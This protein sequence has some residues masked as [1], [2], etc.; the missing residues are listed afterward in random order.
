MTLKHSIG[1]AIVLFWCVMNFLLIKRQIWAP[2]PPL[3]VRGTEMITEPRQEWWGIY[4]RGE[5][6]GYTS[7]T[8]EPHLDGY[9][10]TD[11]SMLRLN[12]MGTTRN[13][14]TRLA[15]NVDKEWVLKNFDFELQSNDVHFKSRGKVVPGKLQLEIESAGHTSAQEIALTQPPYLLAALKPL[16]ATQQ[17]E[18][19]KEHFFATFDPSTLSQQITSVV[20]EAR[21]QTLIGN[22]REPAIRFRQKFKGLSVL[23]WIDGQG[24]TLKEESPGG[25]ALL[26]ETQQE[27]K[28]FTGSR[29]VPLDMIA[30][31][32]VP[33]GATITEPES[34]SVLRLKLTGVN[35]ANFGLNQGRQQLSENELRVEREKVSPSDTFQIPL[36]DRRFSSFLQSTAFLQ[37]DHPRIRDLARQILGSETDAL[38]A[39]LRLKNWVY[40]EI[41]K[42]PTVSVPNALEVLQTRKGDCNE[43]TVLF[44]AL[45]RAAGIPARTV[46]GVV[47]LRNAFY[48]H[49]WSE[50]WLGTWISLDSVL[51][52]FPADVTHIKF[53][54]GEIDR[55]VNVL[56]LI[57][58][59][60]IEVL[61]EG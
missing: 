18:P 15:M 55:Q 32:S 51:D 28:G 59:L 16:V 42:E 50:V 48:Y 56:Q 1:L 6:I 17:L 14:S 20:I 21:E 49:A 8:I 53:I 4:Y 47:Y 54:E 13:A 10:L 19:G 37:S 9:Q 33:V 36:Q 45:A 11:D 25:F 46:V 5:K 38:K 31:S 22:K 12:L 30:Q 2:P 7:Q 44:N 29:A 34:R 41:K 40:K 26:R 57:G 43:H 24:R 61:E 3:F 27:A 39:V 60:K 23:S 35:L 58:H 52:Q